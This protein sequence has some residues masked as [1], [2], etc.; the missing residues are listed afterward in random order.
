MYMFQFVH[1]IS[2][3]QPFLFN[4]PLQELCLKIALPPTYDFSVG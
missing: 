2:G 3:L 1:L 4:R